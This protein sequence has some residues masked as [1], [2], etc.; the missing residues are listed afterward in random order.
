METQQHIKA[1]NEN[2][3]IYHRGYLHELGLYE[4]K[5]QNIEKQIAKCKSDTKR[6][7]LEKQM[8]SYEMHIERLDQHMEENTH[9]VQHKIKE[10]SNKLA[11]IEREKHSIKT[12]IEKLRM[13]LEQ[14]NPCDIFDM[15]ECLTNAVCILDETISSQ[16]HEHASQTPCDDQS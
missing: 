3:E 7:I 2:L 1:L 9:K 10:L 5:I 15:L 14:R 6:D 11:V 4:E 16:V 13:G 12:N 8:N